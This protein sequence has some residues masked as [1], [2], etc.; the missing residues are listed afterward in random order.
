MAVS[1]PSMAVKEHE[2]ELTDETATKSLDGI[3][4]RLEQ[5]LSDD[6]YARQLRRS[7]YERSKASAVGLMKALVHIVFER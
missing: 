1:T 5:N 7:P 2:W 4:A 3:L 6:D